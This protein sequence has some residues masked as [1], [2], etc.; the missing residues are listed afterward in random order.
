MTLSEFIIKM[1][2][3]IDK[4][5]TVAQGAVMV[6]R[7][8]GSPTM[9]PAKFTLTYRAKRKNGTTH[10]DQVPVVLIEPEDEEES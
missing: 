4:N 5:R 7:V 2:E 10:Y 3:V 1:T 6:Y 8:P 9:I